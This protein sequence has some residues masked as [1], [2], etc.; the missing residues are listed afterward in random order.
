MVQSDFS[1]FCKSCSQLK[2]PGRQMM[3]LKYREVDS[4][5]YRI[6]FIIMSIESGLMGNWANTRFSDL[7]DKDKVDVKGEFKF[8]S[9]LADEKR[10]SVVGRIL[11]AISRDWI[12]TILRE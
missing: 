5:L 10:R 9:F 2:E 7:E 4:S 1:K 6:N 3:T 8:S 11:V 12:F